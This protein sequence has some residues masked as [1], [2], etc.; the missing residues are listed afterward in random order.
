MDGDATR[1][2]MAYRAQGAENEALR[3]QLVRLLHENESLR[4][5]AVDV[6]DVE[7]DRRRLREEAQTLRSEAHQ[8]RTELRDAFEAAAQ[9]RAHA[10][11]L[12][13]AVRS[14]ARDELIADV[15]EE[16]R[17]ELGVALA[18]ELE[19]TIRQKL[20]RERTAEVLAAG[21]RLRLEFEQERVQL[22]A[23]ENARR[24][25]AAELAAAQVRALGDAIVARDVRAVAEREAKVGEVASVLIEQMTLSSR[26]ARAAIRAVAH[27]AA[28]PPR[29]PPA[30]YEPRARRLLDTF[31]PRQ[32]A[33]L[34]RELLEEG[35]ASPTAEV[36]RAIQTPL[37]APARPITATPPAEP[38]GHAALA[39]LQS[40]LEHERAVRANL[41][42]IVAHFGGPETGALHGL[43]PTRDSA[44]AEYSA[45]RAHATRAATSPTGVAAVQ[46][47][48]YSAYVAALKARPHTLHRPQEAL[49]FAEEHI[50]R[51]NQMAFEASCSSTLEGR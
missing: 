46:P 17:T 9:A 48:P 41:E 43:E 35:E 30:E 51:L 49:A 32:R 42:R 7:A 36:A 39:L 21:H 1:A 34:R 19:R 3:I 37:A 6:H 15:R 47:G 5:F 18:T 33:L 24:A 14:V 22:L 50:A 11:D 16:L 10:A 8:L 26:P 27:A 44:D 25:D 28:Q 29:T 20:E 45:A 4:A 23:R 38:H 13:G 12:T 40:A 31:G 2:I